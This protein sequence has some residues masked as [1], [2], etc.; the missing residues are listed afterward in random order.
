MRTTL[1]I[2]KLL[3][4]LGI[5]G[6]ARPEVIPAIQPVL[7]VGDGSALVPPLGAPRA[8]AGGSCSLAAGEYSGLSLQCL[9]SGGVFIE[10]CRLF[11]TGTRIFF[12]T[13]GPADP[14]TLDQ[15][16]TTCTLRNLG[17]KA[18]KSIVRIGTSNR[19]VDGDN[20]AVTFELSGG[21]SSVSCFVPPGYWF[22]IQCASA[23]VIAY[24]E[25]LF[26]EV[27]AIN[28]EG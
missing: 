24:A 28:G 2:E 22:A 1:G 25:I 19:Q 13:V 9:A 7:V 11:S 27:P 10:R 26:R 17:P 14:F 5:E 12:Y 4:A 18:A 3:S 6:G 15:L 21:P 16:G 8:L 23:N 20:P